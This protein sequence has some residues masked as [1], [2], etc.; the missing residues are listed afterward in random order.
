MYEVRDVATLPHSQVYTGCMASKLHT[1][2]LATTGAYIH[3]GHHA[4]TTHDGGGMTH[5]GFHTPFCAG[6][7][8]QKI[9]AALRLILVGLAC[10]QNQNK[11]GGGGG[12]NPTPLS[13]V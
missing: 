4:C 6:D 7:A 10:V 9:L 2:L 13:S 5:T 8:S 11:L 3:A 1:T 12:G